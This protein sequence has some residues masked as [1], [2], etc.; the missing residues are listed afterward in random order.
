MHT[1]IENSKLIDTQI[2]L[3]T[4][5]LFALALF[6]DNKALKELNEGDIDAIYF[7]IKKTYINKKKGR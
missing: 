6:G 7:L 1:S 3:K 2:E 4:I 5:S